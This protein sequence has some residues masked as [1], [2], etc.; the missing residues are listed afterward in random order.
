MMARHQVG[1]G[2]INRGRSA[3]IACA[4]TRYSAGAPTMRAWA[5]AAVIPLSLKLPEEDS[6]PRTG[7]KRQPAFMPV[8]V[9]DQHRSSCSIVCPSG[10]CQ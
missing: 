7:D 3:G 10:R 2:T 8:Y 6:C 9:A 1:G 4:G 5:N